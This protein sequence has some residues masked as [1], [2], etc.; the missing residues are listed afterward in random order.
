MVHHR[1][2]HVANSFSSLSDTPTE[3]STLVIGD[4]VMSHVTTVKCIPGARAGIVKGNSKQL[5]GDKCEYSWIIIHVDVNDVRLRQSEITKV[6]VESVCNFA[7][8]NSVSVAFS[9]PGGPLL[10]LTSD[11]MFIK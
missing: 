1:P 9:V 6:N 4:Y 7:K 8:T 2:L 11:D 3:K 10:T 5:A